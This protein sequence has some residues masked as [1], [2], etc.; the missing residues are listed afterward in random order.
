LATRTLERS[1]SVANERDGSVDY[2]VLLALGSCP[3]TTNMD[4]LQ[5]YAFEV[6]NEQMSNLTR[7]KK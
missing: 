6:A 3:P 7:P 2:F 5:E 1:L 4:V